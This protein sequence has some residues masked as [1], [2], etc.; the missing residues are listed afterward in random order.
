M[1]IELWCVGVS[2]QGEDHKAECLQE[3]FSDF[4]TKP[5]T[6]Q[7]VRQSLARYATTVLAFEHGVP[8]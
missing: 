2:P 6:P 7:S 4:L 5:I 3:G 1:L 8:V